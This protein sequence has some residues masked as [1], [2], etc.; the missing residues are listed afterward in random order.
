MRPPTLTPGILRDVDVRPATAHSLL[1]RADE[2]RR[3]R[4]VLDGE[5]GVVV[6]AAP[7]GLGKTKVLEAVI[8]DARAEGIQTL[9]ARSSELERD[10]A[11]GVVRQ[12]LEAAVLDAGEQRAELLS[13]AARQAA[14][15]LDL[16][17]DAALDRDVHA[18]LHGLYW[19]LV[20]LAAGEPLLVA[21]DDLQWA[22]E[23]SLRW[24]AYVARRLER[25]PITLLATVRTGEHGRGAELPAGASELTAAAI[26]ELVGHVRALR[27]EP[28]PLSVNAVAEV[29]E[30]SL[31]RAPDEA[32][33]RACRTQTG[34]NAFLVSELVA[35]L[36]AEDVAPVAG[37]AG[38]MAHVVPE[39]VGDTVRRHL[40]RVGADAR[41]LAASVAV[42][43]DGRDPAL[44]GELAGMDIAR[45]AAAAGEL[46]AAQILVDAPELRFRHPLLRAAVLAQSPPLELAARHGRAA[47]LLSRHGA[48]SARV[49]T[50]LLAATPAGAPWAV[51][52]LRAAARSARAQGVPEQA[53]ALLRRAL[54]EPPP[55]DAQRAAVLREL[56][57]VELD[58]LDSEAAEHLAR[59]RELTADPRERAE[60]ALSL[61][62]CCYHG[63]H[64]HD[65]VD[66]LLAA[67]DEARDDPALREE[68]LRLEALLG[69]VG[70]YDLQTEART[71]G[72]LVDLAERLEGATPA[73]RLVQSMALS[74]RP[75][76]NADG[77]YRATLM[78]ER[79][80]AERVWPDPQGSASSRCTCTRAVPT[81]PARTPTPW[82]KRPAKTARRC[83][84]R[85][86]SSPARAS[87]RT[88]AT[89]ARPTPTSR[90]RL[91]S[92]A[93]SAKAGS[94]TRRSRCGPPSWSSSA[95]S[96]RPS[97]C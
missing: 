42:L 27:V 86:R 3:I 28:A 84:T 22:D 89:C 75:G 20:N 46:I 34:G 67:I 19:L 70:R 39:R 2:L 55:D 88:S 9:I 35:E 43:G 57:A 58:M 96:G 53:V 62:M 17:P 41:A 10:F 94:R 33:A 50:H 45:V 56:G 61:A 37:N 66:A 60:I 72:R 18:T 83:A 77:L 30:R 65:G 25:V 6:I 36:A 78:A 85:S 16:D 5:G 15:V 64:H 95:G 48:P 24:L 93:S 90:P 8:A 13:G 74:E 12:L 38:L 31:G 54:R 21:V 49:A 68:W 82:C 73:E 59:A 97:R 23:P 7:A 71:R 63:G 29:L 79:A 81:R 4:R 26:D 32:F 47:Q 76:P 14:A 1:E 80:A 69:L 11:F 52:E 91:G 87:R 44:T 40:A 51:G 92:G